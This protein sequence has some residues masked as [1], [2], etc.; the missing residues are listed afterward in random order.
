MNV[1]R[2]SGSPGGTAAILRGIA[3]LTCLGAALGGIAGT[4]DWPLV[5]TFFGAVEGLAAGAVAGLADGLLLSYPA[6]RDGPRR[7]AVGRDPADR[8]ATRPA[9]LRWLIRAGSG[10]L[11]GAAAVVAELVYAGPITLPLAA[12][13][14][15]V[16]VAA[17]AGAGFGPLIRYGAELGRVRRFGRRQVPV[18]AGRVVGWGAVLGLALGAVGGLIVGAIVNLP[19]APFAAIEGAILGA[20][21][22]TLLALLAAGF[23]VLPTLRARR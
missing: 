8:D 13:V 11:A 16:A 3:Y 19:T 15:L 14:A 23:V 4:V 6:G 21:S 22:G 2:P 10:A 17:L 12:A 18:T 5:G 7:D 20:V 9:S 1:E